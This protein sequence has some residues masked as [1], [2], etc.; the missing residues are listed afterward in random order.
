MQ[1]NRQ[2]RSQHL[3]HEG[4]SGFSNTTLEQDLRRS[5]MSCMLW[6]NAFYED[7]ISIADRIS[8]LASKLDPQTVA[9]IAIEAREDMKLRHAP[10][11]LLTVLCKTGSGTSLVSDTIERVI[12]RADELGEFVA[13]Y[14]QQNG[15]DS[16]LSAQMKK[17]LARAFD[18]FDE[19]QLQKYTK[20]DQAWSLRDVMFMVHPKPSEERKALYARLADQEMATADTWEV[21]LSASTDK[22]ASWTRLLA[23]NRVGYMALLRN[24]RNMSQANVERELVV[25]ALKARKGAH[26]VLPFRFVAAAKVAP[27]YAPALDEALMQNIEGSK[28]FTGSTLVLVDVSGSMR[29]SLSSRS[30]LTRLDAA[31]ALASVINADDMRVFCFTDKV[32]EVPAYK[33]LAGIDTIRRQ[34]NGM[35]LLGNAVTELNKIDHDRIIVITDEQSAD[36][37]PG[38]SASKAYMINIASYKN[39][40]G[41]GPWTHIDGFSEK[42]INYIHEFEN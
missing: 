5:V 16:S 22:K 41:Y 3:T 8:D 36:R 9:N 2:V 37:V 23:E 35:T 18:K 19:Y 15:Q 12:Q 24:L 20:R 33:G 28:Q 10:L 27:E 17:G 42:V 34:P 1:L 38:P 30:D 13:I 4:G 25:N 14:K 29:T 26:R 39:G 7:G 32:W 40:V 6:E 21:E 31:A 11:L